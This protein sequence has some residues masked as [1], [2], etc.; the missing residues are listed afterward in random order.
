[1]RRKWHEISRAAIKASFQNRPAAFRLSQLRELIDFEREAWN[2]PISM[3]ADDIIAVLVSIGIVELLEIG[4]VD[5]L[6]IKRLYAQRHLNPFQVA[7]ALRPNS[8]LSHSTAA[9]VHLLTRS[10]NKVVYVTH[11]QSK[12]PSAQSSLT[13][14]AMDRAFLKPQRITT[15]RYSYEG[16]ELMLLNGK[17]TGNLGVG[18]ATSA[19]EEVEVTRIERTLI[20]MTVRPDYSGGPYQVLE[21]YERAADR[22]A[23]A[24]LLS[25]LKR[26]DFIYPY[27][28]SIGFY[29]EKAGYPAA[30]Y[31]R[32]RSFEFQYDFYLVHAMTESVYDEVWR[33]HVP[34]GMEIFR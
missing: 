29:L 19:G 30:T 18:V 7:L 13:Q 20:D 33:L 3:G 24:A 9:Q 14:E 12:K 11:E 25:N 17:N 21:A 10:Q 8:Y 26:L 31:E 4:S 34:A 27:H 1:M 28:Q 15:E 22:L 32:L 6:T 5:G 16:W 2:A 23:L